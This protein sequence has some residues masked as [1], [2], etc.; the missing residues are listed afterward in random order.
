MTTGKLTDCTI[1]AMTVRLLSVRM[2]VLVDS[3]RVCMGNR[4]RQIILRVC[5][6]IRG[7]LSRWSCCLTWWHQEVMKMYTG[8]TR[9]S[10]LGLLVVL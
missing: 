6:R 2:A 8:T 7:N 4:V 9:V 1:S 5:V 3:V 10:V